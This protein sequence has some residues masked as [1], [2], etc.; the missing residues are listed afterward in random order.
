MLHPAGQIARDDQFEM[1]YL[2]SL[3]LRQTPTPALP[4]L[5]RS[6]RSSP[7]ARKHIVQKSDARHARLEY[8]SRALG[9]IPF[10]DDSDRHYTSICFG[11]LTLI[12]KG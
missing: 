9:E 2:V 12:L 11:E 6:E 10:N 7:E 3:K 4:P 8:P 5:H 1:P